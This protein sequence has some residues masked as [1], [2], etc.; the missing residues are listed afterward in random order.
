MRER[1]YT[2]E[3]I[4]EIRAG[5]SKKEFGKKIYVFKK[6]GSKCVTVHRNTIHNWESGKTELPK[7]VETFLS[8]VLFDYDRSH[9]KTLTDME[10]RNQRYLY[11]R[12]SM[13]EMLG[14]DLYCRNLHDALLIQVCRGIISFKDIPQLEKEL[15]SALDR[16]PLT[17]D[18]KNLYAIERNTVAISD[19]LNK[20]DNVEELKEVVIKIHRNSFASANR[21]VG[22]RMR[23]IYLSRNRYIKDL[24]MGK[25]IA[26]LAPNYRDSY[27]RMFKSSFISRNWMIDL[28][29]HLRFSREE[30]ETVLEAAHMAPLTSDEKWTNAAE[31]IGKKDFLEKLKIM[32]LIGLYVQDR[33]SV[34]DCP[35][36]DYLL[37]SFAYYDQGKRVMKALDD[38]LNCEDVED[39]SYEEVWEKISYPSGQAWIAYI[40]LDNAD[41]TYDEEVQQAYKEEKPDYF[42]VNARV[43][44]GI[45]HVEELEMIHYMV[46]LFYTVLLGRDYTGSFVERD[47]AE[48]RKI[49][50]Y[51]DVDCGIIYR[52]ITQV[53]GVFLSGQEIME[54][55]DHR[56]YVRNQVKKTNTR[57]MNLPS[58]L[59][60]LLQSIL[61]L[62]SDESAQ[63]EVD[64]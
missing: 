29:R 28:C 30:I 8:F 62:Q 1:K 38:L 14:I 27:V 5:L 39:L 40:N 42:Y 17:T 4:T 10:Q 47:L 48:I 59:E 58:I 23:K 37:E 50:C 22:A 32:F 57:A 24:P 13:R 45:K 16:V 61:M 11:V 55:V 20:V 12:Q 18:E 64:C 44:S 63:S 34:Y 19:D 60:D 9:G 7:D 49:A 52:F 41:L 35:P 31:D 46:S 25:A 21:I 26:N 56:F 15:E 43:L 33:F 54:T 3:W 51:R 2:P 36:V 6:N 53:L